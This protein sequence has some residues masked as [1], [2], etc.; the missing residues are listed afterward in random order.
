[1]G[2]PRSAMFL[3][4]KIHDDLGLTAIAPELNQSVELEF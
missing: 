2:E 4:Q 1:M 3:A